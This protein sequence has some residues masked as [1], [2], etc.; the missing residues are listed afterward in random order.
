[1]FSQRIPVFRF[2]LF[3]LLLAISALAV[4]CQVPVFR[5]AL[6]RWSADQYRYVVLCESELTESQQKLADSLAG[7]GKT[8]GAVPGGPAAGVLR[9]HRMTQQSD[10]FLQDLWRQ[11]KVQSEPLLVCLFPRTAAV[12]TAL[13]AFTCGL[14]DQAVRGVQGSP[15][16][17]VGEAS[18]V[19]RVG[20]VVISGERSGGP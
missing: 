15:V 3:V 18:A 12:E 19:G 10:G 8:G 11:R 4:A 20:G 7:L 9:V 17:G 6:E 5:F 2:G 16:H 1:M 14:N 13:P